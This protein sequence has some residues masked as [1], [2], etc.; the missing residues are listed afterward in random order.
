MET[1]HPEPLRSRAGR[2]LTHSTGYTGSGRGGTS[3]RR[4]L[5]SPRSRARRPRP[6]RRRRGRPQR[7]RRGCLAEG[8]QSPPPGRAD[9]WTAAQPALQPHPR[10]PLP[11]PPLQL[12]RRPP[13][14]PPLACR[15]AAC[16]ERGCEQRRVDLHL[17]RTCRDGKRGH[18]GHVGS[19]RQWIWCGYSWTRQRRVRGGCMSDC[20]SAGAGLAVSD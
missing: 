6:D 10:P 15:A 1:P 16:S 14:A 20:L 9:A 13:L 4:A 3:T 18:L 17:S 7:A 11:R 8:R 12:C 19:E 5:E 2:V